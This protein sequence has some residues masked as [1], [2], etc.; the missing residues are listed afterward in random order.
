MGMG[1]QGGRVEHNQERGGVRGLD[2]IIISPL[3]V[4]YISSASA[5]R[6]HT[7]GN[8]SGLAPPTAPPLTIF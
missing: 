8:H 6:V 5:S 2:Y 7:G 3:S 4:L 1:R